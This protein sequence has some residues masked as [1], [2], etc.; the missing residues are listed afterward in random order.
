MRREQ[1]IQLPYLGSRNYL[2]GTTL[3]ASLWSFVPGDAE[4]SFKVPRF[5]RSDVIHVIAQTAE[6][7]KPT[8]WDAILTWKQPMVGGVVTASAAPVS[9]NP[10]RE[11][12]DEE[13]IVRLGRFSRDSVGFEEASPY[14]FLPTIVALQKAY[15][16]RIARAGSGGQ[17]IFTRLDLSS[18]PRETTGLSL[19]SMTFSAGQTVCRSRVRLAGRDLGDLYFAWIGAK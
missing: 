19:E 11:P 17:W 1:T 18:L 2:Q 6:E 10:K 15:L 16:L 4:F 8:E 14:P 3:F 5:I 9:G 13:S 7:S 12:F